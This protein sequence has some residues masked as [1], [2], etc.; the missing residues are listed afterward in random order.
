MFKEPETRVEGEGVVGR[1]CKYSGETLTAAAKLW[2]DGFSA[3]EIGKRLKLSAN[4]IKGLVYRN[5]DDFNQKRQ[6][7][8][9]DE[10]IQL[11]AKLW[12][13][14]L[15]GS[16]VGKR[17]GVSRNVVIGLAH[18]N[19]SLFVHK[20]KV[21]LQPKFEPMPAPK[22]GERRSASSPKSPAQK[23]NQTVNLFPKFKA[24]AIPQA[25]RT[26]HDAERLIHAKELHELE[27]GEC[28]WGLNHGSP[29]LF[30]AAARSGL[31]PYCEHHRARAMRVVE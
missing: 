6:Q 21:T 14:G 18:R 30:C 7:S 4:A 17:L 13:E 31:S 2:N 29:F 10:T 27:R 16:Q 26:L 15:S 23:P 5:P 19:P 28:R 24:Y 20:G 3:S 11:A 25:V 8:H 22:R 12:N 9:S 1:P